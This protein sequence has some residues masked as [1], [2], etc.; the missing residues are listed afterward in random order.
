MRPRHFR[1]RQQLLALIND[2]E[3]LSKV[4]GAQPP[5]PA[6]QPPRP[7]PA[8]RALRSCHRRAC[9][10]RAVI[11]DDDSAANLLRMLLRSRRFYRDPR[12]QRRGRAPVGDPA[13]A[14]LD[15]AGTWRCMASR[16]QFLQKMRESSN[17][18]RAPW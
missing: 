16:L 11:D 2:I 12:G 7:C 4:E 13:S 1:Q 3:D 6:R 10:Y 15:H 5:Q 18:A 9:T 14:R 17:V 8:A